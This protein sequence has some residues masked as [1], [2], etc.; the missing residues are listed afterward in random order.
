MP[1][2]EDFACLKRYS[3]RLKG[4]LDLWCS[5]AAVDKPETSLTL[6]DLKH[7]GDLVGT[8]IFTL[9]HTVFL[10]VRVYGGSRRQVACF[11]GEESTVLLLFD[12]CVAAI[13]IPVVTS[14]RLRDF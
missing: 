13:R 8:G 14:S 5:K 12:E 11:V 4:P 3:V 6:K 9:D 1:A 2:Y 7:P 10:Q